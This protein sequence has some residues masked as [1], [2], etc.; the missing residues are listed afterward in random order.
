MPY[1]Y[2]L[3]NQTGTYQPCNSKAYHGK[4]SR[5]PLCW[6]P[7]P[8]IGRATM[9]KVYKNFKGLQSP[10]LTQYFTTHIILISFLVPLLCIS[11]GVLE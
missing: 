3:L 9:T 8:D 2:L 11:D 5:K 6:F 10:D 7:T 4:A 1:L